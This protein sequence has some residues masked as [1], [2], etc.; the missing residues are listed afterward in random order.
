MPLTVADWLQFAMLVFEGAEEMGS[1]KIS[2][3]VPQVGQPYS[4][5]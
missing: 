1:S 2:E 5:V 3:L 4:L